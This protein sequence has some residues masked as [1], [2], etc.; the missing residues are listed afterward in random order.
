MYNS[1]M[2]ISPRQKNLRRPAFGFLAVCSSFFLPA[3]SFA[4]DGAATGVNPDGAL[5]RGY[6]ELQRTPRPVTSTNST[7]NGDVTRLTTTNTQA[8]L[9][10]ANVQINS[11]EVSVPFD[12]DQIREE[13]QRE[14]TALEQLNRNALENRAQDGERAAQ[15]ALGVDFAEEATRLG[16][17][18]TAANDA[19]S[20][21]LQWYSLA[22]RRGFPGA[23]SL[24]QSG[25]RYF[26]VRVVRNA[27]N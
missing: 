6:T 27:R 23:P 2:N 17:A 10:S 25:I 21:A 3:H 1:L 14:Q 26:P 19:L 11:A 16:F 5:D 24:D 7:G 18:P 12:L 8:S 20:D 22:A 13:V 15:I 4:N 9:T